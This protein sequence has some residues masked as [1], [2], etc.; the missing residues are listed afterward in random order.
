LK[1]RFIIIVDDASRE[2]QNT[3]TE[4]LR[5]QKCG[6]WHYFSDVWFLYETNKQ[7]SAVSLRNKLMEILPGRTA[8]VLKIQDGT[9][10]AAFGQPNIFT[11]VKESWTKDD[12]S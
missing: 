1:N 9:R 10:W 3:V 4:F 11:W 6:Y 5:G 7:W 12:Q 2:Q 8:I